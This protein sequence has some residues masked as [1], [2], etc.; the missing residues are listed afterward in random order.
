MKRN[1]DKRYNKNTKPEDTAVQPGDRD[2]E[3]EIVKVVAVKRRVTAGSTSKTSE[4]ETARSAGLS[5]QVVSGIVC[6]EVSIEL[7]VF[8]STCIKST[9]KISAWR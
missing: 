9:A 2:P 4:G 6:A 5:G 3:V 8:A 7:P 1:N